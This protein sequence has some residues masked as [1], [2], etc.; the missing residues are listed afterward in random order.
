MNT[1]LHVA[2]LPFPT[3]QG[4]QACIAAM[5]RACAEEGYDTHLLTYGQGNHD[6]E[7]QTYTSHGLPARIGGVRTRDDRSGPSLRKL[8]TDAR[9]V[10]ALRSLVD[11]IA[12][13]QVIAHH[14]EAAL[15]CQVAK[16]P[17]AWVAH[18]DLGNELPS[19]FERGAPAWSK[20]G[21]LVDRL[22]LSRAQAVAAVSPRLVEEIARHR[23]TALLPTPWLVS[24]VQANQETKRPELIY[25]GN[26]DAY[27]GWEDVVDALAVLCGRGYRLRCTLLTASDPTPWVERAA[28]R[29]I[30]SELRI[31]RNTEAQRVNAMARAQ[32]G[33]V[34]RRV[35]GGLPIKLLDH[36][37]VGHAVVTQRRA[38][39]G[40]D[41]ADAALVV[42]DDAPE[43][44]AVA[45][46]GLVHDVARRQQ[47]ARAGLGYL[48]ARHSDR[49]FIRSINEWLRDQKS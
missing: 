24:S 45:L 49:A 44:L 36:W 8:V 7:G 16:V 28:D 25:A 35:A 19:Y 38:L 12:P 6:D 46:E 9:M 41:A 30:L 14:V 29:G 15:L 13:D 20:A 32:I 27:Q 2:A 3:R 47:L 34:P 23:H 48:S 43:A 26:L 39:A 1:L 11:R 10:R 40:F 37:S 17:Y 18:T 42:A 5:C 22:C 21:A 4:T 31:V 33:V